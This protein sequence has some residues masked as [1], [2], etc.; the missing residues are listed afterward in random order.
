MHSRAVVN[1]RI[2][3]WRGCACFQPSS[4]CQ[5]IPVT[6]VAKSIVVVLAAKADF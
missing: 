5:Y 4:T 6:D 1:G 3:A 2:E